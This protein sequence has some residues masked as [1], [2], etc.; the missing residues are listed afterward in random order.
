[1]PTTATG[2]RPARTTPRSAA[3]SRSPPRSAQAPP[4]PASKAKAASAGMSRIFH[5][6][7]Y[8]GVRGAQ[9]KEDLHGN[10]F[11]SVFENSKDLC[12]DFAFGR[13]ARSLRASQTQNP[14]P[15]RPVRSSEVSP[16]RKILR[17]LLDSEGSA[18]LSALFRDVAQSGSAPALGAGCR[19]FESCRPDHEFRLRAL[20]SNHVWQGSSFPYQKLTENKELSADLQVTNRCHLVCAETTKAPGP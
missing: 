8:A 12:E 7:Y 11:V 17:F 5:R 19:R 3:S 10:G 16:K 4:R 15:K 1:M 14:A 9:A 6:R 18:I 2:R 20:P 13:V